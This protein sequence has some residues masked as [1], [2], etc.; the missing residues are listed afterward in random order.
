LSAR[1]GNLALARFVKTS[2]FLRV[3]RTLQTGSFFKQKQAFILLVSPFIL[4]WHR[5][6]TKS[7]L[8]EKFMA[9][10]SLRGKILLLLAGTAFMIAFFVALLSKH[11]ITRTI[12]ERERHAITN[13]M[14]LASLNIATRWGALLDDKIRTIRAER[15]QLMEISTLIRFS[16]ESR[17][18]EA[19]IGLLTR[20]QAQ[21]GVR[22]WVNRLSLGNQRR[23][24]IYD[25]SNRVL[26]STDAAMIGQ[27]LS[28]LLDIKGRRLAETM[29]E[30]SRSLD[31][32][33]AIYITNGPR[34]DDNVRFGYF[35]YFE[36]WDWVLVVSDSAR[37]ITQEIASQNDLKAEIRD[38]LSPLVLAQSG[39]M[40]LL[41]DDG[42]FVTQPPTSFLKHFWNPKERN[43]LRS[44][45][46]KF[47]KEAL[48]DSPSRISHLVIDGQSWLIE[49]AYF[50][51]L[52]W[53]LVAMVPETDLT[54]TARQLV[55]RQVALSAAI[56]CLSLLCAFF[57]VRRI[58]HPLTQLTQYAQALPERDFLSPESKTPE[59]IAALPAQSRDEIGLLAAAFLFMDQRLRENILLLVRET[60]SRERIESELDIARSIQLGLMP[61]PLETHLSPFLS[62][63]ARMLP[64]REVGGDL[65]DYFAIPGKRLCLV[66]GD[67]SGKGVPAA[68]FMAISRT[69]I[70]SAAR[71]E[72]DPGRMMQV[73]NQRLSEN[74]PNLM[75]VT[76][77]LGILNLED[78][79][80][81][82]VN[83][84][85]PPPILITKD[86]LARKLEGRSGPACGVMENLL[87]HDFFAHLSPGETLLGYT[88]GVTEAVDGE[89]RQYGEE[90]LM[91]TLGH[92]TKDAKETT[93]RLLA[94]VDAFTAGTEAFD[95]I[96]LITVRLGNVQK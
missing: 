90:R 28:G 50:R 77:F 96:T 32:D 60:A 87:Y 91:E 75:F 48:S 55:D 26:A 83:A 42:S 25:R 54:L 85:H 61:V 47:K 41:S 73:I 44:S 92:P 95:D 63:E 21:A 58:V 22:D 5:I 46:R 35:E 33:F 43:A 13:T 86:G 16:L 17:A 11:D 78:G 1:T 14:K 71:D 94:D 24:L 36:P 6:M 23:M 2:C 89:G 57:F 84:G 67:V 12:S 3:Q 15:A 70:R 56:L 9:I 27:D 66:I 64:A 88:D 45:L 8:R 49:S 19:E 65:Y 18:R 20:D 29:R 59:H 62:L 72:T 79:E 31:Y 37:A 51:P 30:E 38:I 93:E 34:H 40:F 4:V 81:C 52:A 82:Y 80:L 10:R 7:F 68:L 53:T 39:F 76:L 74:N 69:L